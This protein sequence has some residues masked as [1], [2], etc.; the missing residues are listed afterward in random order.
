MTTLRATHIEADAAIYAVEAPYASDTDWPALPY[1]RR[2]D[3]PAVVKLATAGPNGVLLVINHDAAIQVD[4]AEALADALQTAIPMPILGIGGSYADRG[5]ADVME[6]TA[7]TGV[8]PIDGP[9]WVVVERHGVSARVR[10]G[11]ELPLIAAILKQPE[12]KCSL[13]DVRIEDYDPAVHDT[14]GKFSVGMLVR[15]PMGGRVLRVR[16]VVRY[17]GGSGFFYGVE[18]LEGRALKFYHENQLV[19]A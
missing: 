12:G 2:V 13:S 1:N 15:I 3:I 19:E 17:L 5:Q 14:C 9:E 16:K 18:L 7:P 10:K 6:A 8:L 4:N 11:E